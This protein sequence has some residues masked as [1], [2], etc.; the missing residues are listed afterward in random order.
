LRLIEPYDPSTSVL[1]DN[2]KLAIS[3]KGMAHYELSTKDNVYFYQMALTTG[4]TDPEIAA[5][6]RSYYKLNRSYNEIT[7]NVRRKFSEY[8]LR[9]DE[10]FITSTHE[11]EDYEC[12]RDLIR[13][14]RH[15]S[16]DRN[17]NNGVV[18]ESISEIIG[19]VLVG[20]VERYD[21]EKDFGFI[22]LNE[23]NQ[24]VYFK[25]SNLKAFE[26]ENIYDA[27]IVHCTL[28][29][30]DKGLVVHSILG[31]VEGKNDLKVEKCS[32]KTF[33]EIRGF[34]FVYI[35]SSS[36][37][38]FFHKTAFPSNFYE[39]LREGLELNAE[40]RLRDDGKLQ[41]RRCIDLI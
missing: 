10:K 11:K 32:I 23:L 33:N 4:I 9:E 29:S 3:Y 22:K 6:I 1:D 5:S 39:H 21:P 36:K 7:T 12:Q 24:D 27:D 2:Q 15:F 38:V 31:F 19:K 40:I 13:D 28:S 16:I 20:K 8:L 14:M 34:G 35:G 26:L 17:G 25:V 30:G 18:P 41:V 37:E